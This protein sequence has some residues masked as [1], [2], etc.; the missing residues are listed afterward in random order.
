MLRRVLLS[1]ALIAIVVT[2]A[3]AAASATFVLANGQKYSGTL[4]YGRGEN[5]IVDL[6]FHVGVSGKDVALGINDVV[7]ID[8]AGGTPS[9]A[10]LDALPTDKTGVMVMRDG[11]KIRGY[12]HNIIGN[13]NVQWVPE[14][15]Q[16]QNYPISNVS[17]LYLNGAAARQVYGAR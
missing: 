3:W 2:A 6:K 5:N 1:A 16:R 10:E 8:F 17:R 11:S 15:R 14:G 4:I 13:D 9:K 7:A 12:L